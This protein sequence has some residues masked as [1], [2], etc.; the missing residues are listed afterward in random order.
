M[1]FFES[2]H[3]LFFH[4]FIHSFIWMLNITFHNLEQCRQCL[5]Y[6]H[7]LK[8]LNKLLSKL[9]LLIMKE[10][11][12]LSIWYL[13]FIVLIMQLN[14]LGELLCQILVVYEDYFWKSC[15]KVVNFIKNSISLGLAI[16]PI[17]LINL[18]TAILKIS[19]FFQ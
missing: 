4:Q 11:L 15:T 18:I 2:L 9:N 19:D 16:F 14:F 12:I 5:K 7:L 1:L 10:M 3:L 6:F 13:D 17:I 8:K